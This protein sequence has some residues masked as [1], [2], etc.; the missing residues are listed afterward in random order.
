MLPLAALGFIVAGLAA[1]LLLPGGSPWS[2]RIWLA[3]LAI[4]GTPVLWTTL[5]GI[6][7]RRFAA[8]LVAALAIAAALALREPLAGLIVVVMQ[9]GGEALER[10][11]AGRASRAVRA[12]EE[13]APRIAHRLVDGRATDIA[14]EEVLVGD[15]LL[16]RP[17]ELVPC[18]AIVVD[19]RSH[20]D[21]SRLTGEPMPV[22]AVTGTALLSGSTTLDGAITVR[23]TALARESQYARIVDLVRSAQAS[24]APLQRLADRY[25]VWFTPLTLLVCIAAWVVTRDPVRV[26][27]VLVVATPC[28]LIL[29]TPVAM[30]GGIN[31]AA[32]RQIIVRQGGGLESLG[33][34]RTAVF[35]KTGTLTVGLPHVHHVR[36]TPGM[37]RSELLRLAGAVEERSG[38]LL[39][40]TLV[41]AATMAGIDLPEARDI[42]EEP[43][44]GVAGVVEGREVLVGAR[45]LVLERH[46]DS[47]PAFAALGEDEEGLHAYVAIDGRAAG[48]V[49]YADALR[50]GLSDLFERLHALG[51]RRTLLLSGDREAN[52]RSV[53]AAVGIDEVQGDLL[54]EG[55][56]A[57]VR[58]LVE[59]ERELVLMVGD[60]VNDAPA[61]SAATVGI[62]LAGHGGG[63]ST[64]A[65]DVVALVDDLDRVAEAVHI[66]RRTM[67][68]A[69]QSIWAGLGLSGLAML[70]AA[71]GYIP[72]T[73]G[74]LLQEGIDL[75]VIANALRA[76]R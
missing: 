38:H 46:P 70:A 12:L 62:A 67:R 25:A 47:A 71:A 35:D 2:A 51:I 64:E 7:H 27:A 3:G 56:V 6:F 61:L 68:I 45:S 54:P 14:A 52:A 17:G 41:E 16:V 73:V 28:P 1:W 11:A 63:I 10:F 66:G 72:P 20:V 59:E 43:G 26:L 31:A 5:R 34:V 23:A 36:V 44:R 4:T 40:R 30:V 21:T 76:A 53:A 29:A 48:I 55:K 39:A 32:R 58:Q 18:D 24:K 42:H 75:A 49:T 22:S 74:A 9:T 13:A 57:V 60:G 33:D 15:L 69:R 50:P 65:A 37:E 8:D 19:G